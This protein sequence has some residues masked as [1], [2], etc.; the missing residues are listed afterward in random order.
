MDTAD[1]NT[2]VIHK[3]GKWRCSLCFLVAQWIEH[4]SGFIRN[5]GGGVGGGFDKNPKMG[6]KRR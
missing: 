6:A 4:P 2:R 5:S 3:L 1:P